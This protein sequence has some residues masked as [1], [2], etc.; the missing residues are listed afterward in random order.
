MYSCR[1][2]MALKRNCAIEQSIFDFPPNIIICETNIIN[3]F[4]TMRY[5]GTTGVANGLYVSS[6]SYSSKK[7][8]T[9]RRVFN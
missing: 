4:I 9:S 5:D 7:Y 8:Y 1:L 2:R 3:Y 6:C